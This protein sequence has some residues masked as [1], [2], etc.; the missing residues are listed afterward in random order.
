MDYLLRSQ[1][2]FGGGEKNRGDP[3][4]GSLIERKFKEEGAVTLASKQGVDVV[5]DVAASFLEFG[6]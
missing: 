2:G 3:F 4:F 1:I 5:A 6:G